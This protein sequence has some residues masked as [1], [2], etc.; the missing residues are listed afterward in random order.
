MKIFARF[1]GAEERPVTALTASRLSCARIFCALFAL[2]SL[3]IVTPAAPLYAANRGGAMPED[4]AASAVNS[5]AVDLYREFA[6]QDGALN[7]CFSPYSISSAF[8]M[9][10]AGAAGGTAAEMRE[11]LYYGDGIHESNAALIRGLTSAPQGSG[12]MELANSIW[13]QRDFGFLSSFTDLLAAEYAAEITQLDY[14]NQPEKA[15][16]AINNWVAERTKGKITNIIPPQ[17]IGAD[18]T[19]VLV[20]AVYF[21]A[22]WMDKFHETLNYDADFFTAPDASST[23]KMMRSV[24]D[25]PYYETDD[26]QVLKLL[27]GRGAYSILLILPR[28]KYGLS[29]L[30]S[31]FDVGAL[32]I[33]LSK[34]ERRRVDVSIPKFKLESTFNL[35][36]ALSALGIRS[37]FLPGLA[38]FSLMN[39]KRDLFIGMAIHKA[40]V[41]VDE[42]GTEAAAATA[43][44]M[45]RS[46]SFVT[47]EE[48]V[49]FRA[50][51]PFIF[52]IRD[53]A[54]GTILFMGRVARP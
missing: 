3:C 38:D 22:P 24:R 31:K 54:S 48:P 18:T 45:V 17:G 43:V 49:V 13:P 4:A 52:V 2:S 42:K 30:E 53:E 47:L 11:H 7:L 25:T 19:L 44:G 15:R 41:E 10:Y 21:K 6:G 34:P 26:A 32:D 50:D 12:E 46:T 16:S 35:A 20:N 23:A 51:H 29:D 39:G 27:Y 1:T 8:A 9:T 36:N 40:V 14:T 33:L 28:E 37:A 5:L